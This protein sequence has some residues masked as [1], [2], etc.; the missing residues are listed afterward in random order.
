M[1]GRHWH[2]VWL[3]HICVAKRNHYTWHGSL[4]SISEGMDAWCNKTDPTGWQRLLAPGVRRRSYSTLHNLDRMH[5]LPRCMPQWHEKHGNTHCLP[6]GVPRAAATRIARIA[7]RERQWLQE[8]PGH[9]DSRLPS[10]LRQDDHAHVQRGSYDP[11][12]CCEGVAANRCWR[13][14]NSR[15]TTSSA[16]S[17]R[18]QAAQ[19]GPHS[20]CLGWCM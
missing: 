20:S 15:P 6:R 8:V 14:A 18:A 16:S 9:Q 13:S 1:R 10:P 12:C 3:C 5:V 7:A 4:H 17:L 11:S 19:S 2:R